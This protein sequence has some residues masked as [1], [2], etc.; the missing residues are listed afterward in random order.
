MHRRTA[1]VTLRRSPDIPTVRTRLVPGSDASGEPLVKYDSTATTPVLSY[2]H[3]DARLPRQRA[4]IFPRIL[5]Y[6]YRELFPH[7]IYDRLLLVLFLFAFV[8]LMRA[9]LGLGFDEA[10]LARIKHLQAA[11]NVRQSYPAQGVRTR[12]SRESS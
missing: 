11:A 8:V 3:V 9:L 5:I 2:D 1:T 4:P 7:S 10:Q 6:C 12:F